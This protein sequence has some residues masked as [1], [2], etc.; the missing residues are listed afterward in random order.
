V[1]KQKN[2]GYIKFMTASTAG[3][4]PFKKHFSPKKNFFGAN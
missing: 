2:V 3:E 4:V 1:E